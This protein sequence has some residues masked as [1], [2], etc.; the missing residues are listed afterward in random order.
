MQ[1]NI[2][3]KDVLFPVKEV[4]AV[5]YPLDDNQDVTLLDNSGY[6]FIVRE[7]TN[8][9]LSCVTN[10]Y[11]MVTNKQIMDK[12]GPV[13]KNQGAVLK[14]IRSFGNG[15]R[16]KWTYRFPDVKVF[17]DTG[18]YV[19]PQI[20]INNSYDGTSEVSAMGGAYRL[21]CENGLIIGYSLSKQGSRHVVWNKSDDIAK[22]ID[23]VINKTRKVFDD[24][25]PKMIEKEVKE[26][27]VGKIIEMFPGY[28]IEAMIQ[29]MLAHKPK[30]YWDLLNAATWTATHVMKRNSEATHKLELKIFDTVKRFAAQA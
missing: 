24:D 26:K 20:N 28:T 8:D 27:H 19:N 23:D 12:A 16:T 17:V 29:Y 6:K 3:A 21:L 25:F 13:L 7:D 2:K 22:L 11:K 9:V 5:G 1:Q 30:N 10:N 14:D 4:P 18:D 15:S